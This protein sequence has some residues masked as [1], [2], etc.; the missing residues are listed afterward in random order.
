MSD[1][2]YLNRQLVI[3]IV[4]FY[5]QLIIEPKLEVKVILNN[6]KLSKII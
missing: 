5:L 6:E 2:T 1:E 3:F 4:L